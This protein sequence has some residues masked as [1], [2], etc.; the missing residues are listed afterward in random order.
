MA[1]CH[2]LKEYGSPG[3]IAKR[4]KNGTLDSALAFECSLCGL[5]EAVCPEK[6][7]P[8]EFFLTMRRKAWEEGR[9]DKKRYSGILRYEA[10][11]TSRWFSSLMTPPDCETVLF[12][13]CT[14]PGTRPETFMRLW[15]QLRALVPSLGVM[16]DCC[17]KPSHDLGRHEH[18]MRN[19]KRIETK[20]K[21]A[22]VRQVLVACPNCFKVFRTHGDIPVQSVYEILRGQDMCQPVL[23]SSHFLHDPCP[24]RS[25]PQIH[26]AVRDLLR[27][28][29]FSIENSKGKPA[30]TLCCGEG[31]TVAAV[32]PE[33]AR[34]WTRKCSER[35]KGAPIL[36]Y[37]AGCAGFLSQ[38]SSTLHI[39]DALFLSDKIAE[40]TFKPVRSP[41]TYLARL[42]L[43]RFL[44]KDLMQ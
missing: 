7:K 27:Q 11:G 2:F 35:A 24:L 32:R 1:S 12:P 10:L 3:Q 33:F 13:G 21:A 22:G 8:V 23:S 9:V 38:Q 4:V 20:L 29:G 16:L 42:R 39:L 34:E 31:G 18:F 36:T 17:H 30:L 40:G 37:C 41:M 14:F 43:K 5:C 15:K 26:E 19:F 44:R 28:G 25:E 6:F